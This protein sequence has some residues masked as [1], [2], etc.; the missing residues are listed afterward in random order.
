MPPGLGSGG[1]TPV[2][3]AS[4]SPTR[5]RVLRAAGLRPEVIPS[6]VD[7]TSVTRDRPRDLTLALAEAKAAAVA[8]RVGA[9]VVIG[10]DSLLEMASPA[11]LAGLPLGKPAS[12]AQARALWRQMA[13]QTGI[14]FTGHHV[15]DVQSGRHASEA[16]ATAIRFGRP[17]GAEI[18]AYIA[19]GEPLAMAGGFSL[20]GLGGWFIDEIRG[21]YNNVLGI[22]LPLLRRLFAAVGVPLARLWQP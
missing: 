6:E 21:D 13:G 14:L 9:G 4:T 17:T 20:D 1:M 2:I 19:S 7:E 11:E 12:A 22:S 5:L 15:I 3:L 10:C 18:D 16:G 8:Q